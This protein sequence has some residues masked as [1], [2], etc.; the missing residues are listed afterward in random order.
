MSRVRCKLSQ[1]RHTK[2]IS[3]YSTV[4]I[5]AFYQ[6][7]SKNNYQ[8]KYTIQNNTLADTT[9]FAIGNMSFNT[10]LK[11]VLF[12]QWAVSNPWIAF[13]KLQYVFSIYTVY[14]L[15]L[16]Y[17]TFAQWAV[18]LLRR[19]FLSKTTWTCFSEYV[20]LHQGYEKESFFDH[21]FC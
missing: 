21:L 10:V 5:E 17:D 6:R 18:T 9:M 15:Y 16:K 4:L 2:W 13:Y 11:H 14:L 7:S 1:I 19:L 8:P 12:A 20:S 3:T